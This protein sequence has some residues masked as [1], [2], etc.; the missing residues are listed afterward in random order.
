MALPKIILVPTDFSTAADAA[1]ARAVDLAATLGAKVYVMHA[2]QLPI[3]GF[4]EGVLVPTADMA[5]RIITWAQKE[6]AASIA[7]YQGRGV[8]LVSM[9]EQ[10]D[11]R[12]ATLSVAEEISADLIVMGTHGRRGVARALIGS[13]AE[14][15]VRSA[16]VPVLTVHAPA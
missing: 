4:P 11:P 8:E 3:V 16:P 12:A 9:L 5:T 7:R 10:A 14:H 2:Y 6:L 13:L 1:L 15:I